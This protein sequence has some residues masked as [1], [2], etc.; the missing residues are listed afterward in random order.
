VC[1][2]AYIRR[3]KSLV[4]PFFKKEPRKEKNRKRGEISFPRFFVSAE[5]QQHHLA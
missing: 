5:Q 3:R 2:A 4:A 1:A